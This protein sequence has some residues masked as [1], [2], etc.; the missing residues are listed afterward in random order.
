MACI[1]T[2]RNSGWYGHGDP[3]F[4]GL[5]GWEHSQEL[6]I[7][8]IWP[9]GSDFRQIASKTDWSLGSPTW[10]PDGKRILYYEMTRENTWSSHRPQS[11]N[12]ANFT[13]VSVGFVTGADRRVEV[14]GAGVNISYSICPT[15]T[16]PTSTRV[17]PKR[18]S[19]PLLVHM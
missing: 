18:D 2:G 14:E 5:S 8:V 19:I 12:S 15:I 3:T 6:S 9:N 16:L 1:L 4:L 17:A 11:I 13:L 10:S 7:Y